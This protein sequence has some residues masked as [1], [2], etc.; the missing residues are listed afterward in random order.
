IQVTKIAGGQVTGPITETWSIAQANLHGT[1]YYD[2]YTSQLASGG[3]TL[4]IK[5]G[6]P[7]KVLVGS[8]NTCHSVSANGNVLAASYGHSYDETY[9]LTKGKYPPP[10]LAPQ[11]PDPQYEFPAIYPDGTF[12]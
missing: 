1:V 2:T 11:A 5:V 12:L 4:Y 6:Q 3:A 7:A 8:C 9:D 10:A